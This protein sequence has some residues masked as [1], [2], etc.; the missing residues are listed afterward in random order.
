[1]DVVRAIIAYERTF[2]EFYWVLF[3]DS[4]LYNM[5]RDIESEQFIPRVEQMRKIDILV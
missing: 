2:G 5:R 1:M 4:R 3:R